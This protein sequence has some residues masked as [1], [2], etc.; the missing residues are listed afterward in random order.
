M[1]VVPLMLLLALRLPP[2]F[3]EGVCRPMILG[4]LTHDGGSL[5]SGVA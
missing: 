5:N 4:E 3:D 2:F 1:S